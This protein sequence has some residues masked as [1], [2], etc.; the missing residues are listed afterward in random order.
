MPNTEYRITE[1]KGGRRGR[2]GH[3]LWIDRAKKY[4]KISFM[5]YN[6]IY[7]MKDEIAVFEQETRG[8]SLNYLQH[9]QNT[10]K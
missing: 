7:V 5:G 8:A 6:E 1:L 2:R 3:M 9:K 4:H 10:Y